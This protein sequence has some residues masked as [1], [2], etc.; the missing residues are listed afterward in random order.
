VLEAQ[1]ECLAELILGIRVESQGEVRASDRELQACPDEGLSR[2]L[3]VQSPCSVVQHR[4]HR[5]GRPGD[6]R[7]RGLQHVLEEDRD[8]FRLGPCDHGPVALLLGDPRLPGERG[9]PSGEQEDGERSERGHE[10]MAPHELARPVAPR[11]APSRDGEL[12]QMPPDVRGQGLDGRIAPLGSFFER[13]KDDRVEIVPSA[14]S[15]ADGASSAVRAPLRRTHPR[16]P[17]ACWA[18][19]ER[20]RP[21]S[22]EP[23]RGSVSRTGRAAVRS[24]ARRARR[25]GNTRPRSST[26][27]RPR[28][29]R[30]SR[31]RA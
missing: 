12:L 25:P 1:A 30:G 18:G 28:P 20:P 6:R 8:G 29:A 16:T 17:R 13:G 24:G 5:D 14:V 23:P 19:E 31:T 2:Q 7:V 21:R 4:A 9:H 26:R 11:V 15:R 10:R 27:S 22:A 3:P